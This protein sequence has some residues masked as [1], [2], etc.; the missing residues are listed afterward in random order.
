MF[1]RLTLP[2]V[3]VFVVR[4]HFSVACMSVSGSGGAEIRKRAGWSFFDCRAA[5]RD[6]QLV[7]RVRQVVPNASCSTCSHNG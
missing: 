1:S 7:Q 4:A 5:E 2:E 6:E 3:P